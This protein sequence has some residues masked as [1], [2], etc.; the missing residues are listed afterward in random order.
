MAVLPSKFNKR[1]WR[2]LDTELNWQLNSQLSFFDYS[3]LRHS[4][5][6]NLGVKQ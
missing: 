5:P 2:I 6:T 3:K 1:K 4:I